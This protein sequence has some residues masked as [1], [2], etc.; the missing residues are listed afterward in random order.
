[1]E[2]FQTFTLLVVSVSARAPQLQLPCCH[3]F[4][5]KTSPGERTHSSRDGGTVGW[6]DEGNE[7]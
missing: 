5:R 6:R 3:G 7:S 2:E 1:M 4:L